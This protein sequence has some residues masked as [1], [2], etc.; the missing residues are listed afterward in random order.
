MRNKLIILSIGVA[1]TMLIALLIVMIST[2]QGSSVANS[3]LN[4]KDNNQAS[5]TADNENT[6]EL[7][8]IENSDSETSITNTSG[9]YVNYDMSKLTKETNL[10]FFAASWC[11][12]CRQLDNDI[13]SNLNNIPSNVTILKA[14]YDREQELKV[15][16]GVTI[17]HT[18]VQ[19][20]Q[21]GELIN[22][23]NG[24]YNLSTL[25]DLIN[26]I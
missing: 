17:Q 26:V 23:W 8:V 4:V 18:I 6:E 12:S 15:K 9:N 3:N 10:I 1:A 22:R 25:Q 16:Y 24:L 14:D 21:E 20:N 7:E 11:P 2:N 19:V 5:N 13:Q